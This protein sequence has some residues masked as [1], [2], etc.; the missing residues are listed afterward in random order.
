MLKAVILDFDGTLGD[1]S[2]LFVECANELAD[3]FNC[4]RISS[5]EKLKNLPREIF[6]MQEFKIK[7]EKIPDYVSEFIHLIEKKSDK[8]KLFPGARQFLDKL[9][10]KYKL[11][12]L[13]TNSKK[14]IESTL[15]REN[16]KSISKIYS[17][18]RLGKKDKKLKQ[19]IKENN[20]KKEEIIYIGDEVGDA[21]ACKKAGIKFVAVTWGFNSKE[22]LQSKNPHFIADKRMLSTYLNI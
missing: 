10:K 13:S 6:I 5:L 17:E 18:E 20:L 11:F 7:K 15:K 3:K 12:I 14:Y 2:N 22:L 4:R 9:G 19:I 21:D 8:V 1:T 16:I